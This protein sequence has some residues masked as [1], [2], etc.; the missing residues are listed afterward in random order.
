MNT[1]RLARLAVAIVAVAAMTGC[2]VYPYGH[3][4]YGYHAAVVVR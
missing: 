1:K 2:V 3:R 4:Y